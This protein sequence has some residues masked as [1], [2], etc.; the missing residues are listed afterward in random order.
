MLHL[1]L[2]GIHIKKI[3]IMLIGIVIITS[4]I[5]VNA[6]FTPS[7]QSDIDMVTDNQHY[8][9]TVS[10]LTI[11]IQD[12]FAKISIDEATS[13]RRN[14][15]EPLLP[16]ISKTFLLP[17]G[18]KINDV[19]IESSSTIEK[20]LNY[21]IAPGAEPVVDGQTSTS[22]RWC[23]T[24][25]YEKDRLYPETLYSTQSSVGLHQGEHVLF[26]TVHCYPVQYNPV[27]NKIYYRDDI[28]I[29]IDYDAPSS[30]HQLFSADEQ[31]LLVI[32]PSLFADE[33]QPFIQHK[34]DFGLR[35]YGETLE[36][37]YKLFPSGSDDQE[38][39]KLCIKDAIE[40][41]GI[42]YVLLVGGLKGQSKEWYLP[43]RYGHSESEDAYVSDLYYADVYKE[44]EGSIVFE[45][46]DSNGN[47]KYAE[48]HDGQKDIID[49]APDVSIGRL[50]CRSEREVTRVINKIMDYE[51]TK[52]DE[53]WFKHMLLIGG[54]TY[55][56]TDEEYI[57][58]EAEIDTNLSASYMDGFSFTRL[59]AST[60]SLTGQSVVEAAMND[61]AG[62]IHMAGHANP[63]SL[64]THPP[65]NKSE[66]IIILQMYDFYHPTH[67]N[68]KLDNKD[69]LPVIVVGGCHNSQ[70]NVSLSNIWQD[71]QEYGLKK[72]VNFRFFYMEW[73]PQCWSW[74]LTS[75]SDG[76]AIATL[77]NTGLGMG[78]PGEDYV[79]GL[80][81]W[82]FPRF[83]YHYGQEGKQFVGQ[84]HSAAITDYVQ[85]FDINAVNGSE[86]RQMVQQWVLLG[87]PSLKIGGY[88]S[89]F[90]DSALSPG[91]D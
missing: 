66:K 18:S 88:D 47:G 19:Q 50:A 3:S 89:P 5:H 85:E 76:G 71:I 24:E 62:F 67:I 34:N 1:K 69:K 25:I 65:F 87:D 2:G 80:D 49:G 54:D 61:G 42:T 33:I 20:H 22:S 75:K 45:D 16:K 11:S 31:D 17:I 64:V 57:G 23:S 79:T 83:F 9:S 72:Y 84:A 91:K 55:P 43:V 70:F 8:F 78:L 46:W 37:I 41:K 6:I 59:W 4:S 90:E 56:K 81:G 44:V 60:G 39:I 36:S 7:T 14:P 63:A 12:S 13:M 82:L 77:G 48:F 53:A 21:W 32:Y 35:T 73:V 30:L 68:P 15:G 10:N 29:S 51:K 40:T 86:D 28:Q 27:E 74:W 26:Y 52:A 38:K 58:C